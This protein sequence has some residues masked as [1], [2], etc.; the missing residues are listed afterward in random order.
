MTIYDMKLHEELKAKGNQ[1]FW[2]WLVEPGE[3]NDARSK[4]ANADVYLSS[5]NAMTLEGELVNIDGTGNRVSSM[6][7]GPKKVIIVC[8]ENKIAKDYDAAIDRIKNTACP[9]NARRL[10]LST[11]C[12]VTGKCNECSSKER[13]CNVTVKIQYPTTG[14]DINILLVGES[15]GY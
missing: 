12:A 9:A 3:R 11:P 13:M 7:F 4:A 1:V 15:L 2:H 10:K 5:T 14:R 8:G 6:F